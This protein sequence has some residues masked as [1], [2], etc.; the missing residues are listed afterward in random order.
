[1]GPVAAGCTQMYADGTE[2]RSKSGLCPDHAPIF[3]LFATY[4][5]ALPVLYII[6]PPSSVACGVRNNEGYLLLDY[7]QD[8]PTSSFESLTKRETI[9]KGGTSTITAG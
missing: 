6:I 8:Q 4:A 9:R 3:I 5:G 2:E 1:M 7:T